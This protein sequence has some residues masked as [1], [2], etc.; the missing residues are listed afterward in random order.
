MA[1]RGRPKGSTKKRNDNS[2]SVLNFEKQ[3]ANTPVTKTDSIYGI[4][5][6]GEKNTYP[7]D[8]LS[9][10]TQSV[11]MNAC[12]EFA[13]NA[14][15]G[16]GIDYDAMGE[17]FQNPNYYTTWDS[18]IRSLAWDFIMYNA[19]AFQV[20][21]NNDDRTYSFF[22][23][24]ID[25]I[26]LEE[27]DEDGV[28]NNAY[29]CKDWTQPTKYPPVKVP[30]FGFQEEKT[31]RRGEVYL[32]YFHRYNAV[33]NY[34]GLPTYIGGLNAIQAEAQ[35]ELFDL[36]SITNGFTPSGAITLPQVETDEERNQILRNITNMFTGA[37]NANNL[38][39]TF[40]TNNEDKPIEYTPFSM[41]MNNVNLYDSANERT[42]NRIMAAFKIPSKALIGFPADNTGF[43][44]SGEY[45]ESAFALYNVN[46]ANNNRNEIL[47]IIN[48]MFAMNGVEVEIQLKPLKYRI[49]EEPQKSTNAQPS[50]EEGVNEDEAIEREGNTI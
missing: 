45:L 33:N 10:Y 38:L 29:I 1:Q 12:V 48:N 4:V 25:T 23:Q 18:L 39:I 7:Y 41:A 40:R 21:K 43:S 2:V 34:Y 16:D 15:I 3:I 9:L 35:Y 14:I 42:I 6:Y 49:D 27:A 36:K 32:F 26:R 20:I 28:V 13:V 5:K 46:V 44:N 31:I 47:S 24:A 17:D 8:L 37:E 50:D 30:M 19:F 11:T 22:H